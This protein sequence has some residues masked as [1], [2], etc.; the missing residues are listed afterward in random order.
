MLTPI[1][2]PADITVKV[3]ENPR[4]DSRLVV[5]RSL[6]PHLVGVACPHPDVGCQK[7]MLAGAIHRFCRPMPEAEKPLSQKFVRFADDVMR[8]LWKPLSPDIDLSREGW[9]EATPYTQVQKEMLRRL[10]IIMDD[11]GGY[12]AYL[13]RHRSSDVHMFTKDEVY[14]TYKHARCIN[15]R[16][17]DSKVFMG[18]VFRAI[19][20]LIFSHPAF[21]KKIPVAER[22]AFMQSLFEGPGT[23][24]DSDF[25]SLEATFLRMQYSIEINL[26]KY[27]TQLL[28]DRADY[29]R[30]F[31]EVLLGVNR[32]ESKYVTLWTKMRRMSGDNCT[33]L[34]NGIFNLMINLFAYSEL[35]LDWHT[36]VFVVEGDDGKFK[37]PTG[38]HPDSSFYKRLGASIKITLVPTIT[39]AS[40]CGLVFDEVE[41]KNIADPKKVLATVGLT[42]HKYAASSSTTL[43]QLLRAKGLALAYQYPCCPIITALARYILRVTRGSDNSAALKHILRDHVHKWSEV[44]LQ[45][46]SQNS[47]GTI[48][49]LRLALQLADPGPRTRNLMERVFGVSVEQQRYV[50][51]YLDGLTEIQPLEIDLDYPEEWYDYA[52]RFAVTYNG[53]T[54]RVPFQPQTLRHIDLTKFVKTVAGRVDAIS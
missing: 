38:V 50:E 45:R 7:T 15:G 20:K 6:G 24:M 10:G 42:N 1:H 35:G 25:E 9:L 33:S 34:G 43:L 30:F 31:D 32:C 11:R 28:P 41:L 3:R 52:A 5:Q 23:I 26:Y 18:P 19:E 21:I 37:S 16:D 2:A 36:I 51:Q 40:F 53:K 14:P 12:W 17:N 39:E 49:D 46:F 44:D 29:W 27:V 47:A 48:K 54:N 13:D 22:P 8:E 4:D